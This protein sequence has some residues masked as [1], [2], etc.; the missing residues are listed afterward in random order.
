MNLSY[1]SFHS[2]YIYSPKTVLHKSN[3]KHKIFVIYNLLIIIPY[4]GN[5]Y[6]IIYIILLTCFFNFILNNKS[7]KSHYL[8]KICSLITLIIYC[9]NKYRNLDLNQLANKNN[10][11]LSIQINLEKLL[12]KKIF[13]KEYIY[14]I[15]KIFFKTLNITLIYIKLTNILFISTR[16]E[17]ILQQFLYL[18]KLITFKYLFYF[19]LNLSLTSQFLE[20]NIRNFK[21]IYTSIKIKYNNHLNLYIL[22]LIFYQLV[23]NY[24][25]SLFYE[26]YNIT[27]NLWN[28]KI[29]LKNI[30]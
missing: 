22:Y 6:L 9:I 13:L 30:F 28:K 14:L 7:L 4:I 11:I 27:S 12:K 17:K 18:L 10:F 20:K 16:Y 24:I 2:Q 26:T 25:L 21:T 29:S 3:S 15:Q 8:K 5:K 23:N 1:L 19:L